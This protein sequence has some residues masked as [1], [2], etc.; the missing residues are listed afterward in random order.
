MSYLT[1]WLP[2]LDLPKLQEIEKMILL[3]TLIYFKEI[4]ITEIDN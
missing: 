1:K 4:T 2:T 3:I